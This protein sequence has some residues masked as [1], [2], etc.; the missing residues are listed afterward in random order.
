MK[1]VIVTLEFDDDITRKDV[2]TYLK[3]LI[4]DDSLDYEEVTS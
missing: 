2:Y 1:T 4:E 3:D